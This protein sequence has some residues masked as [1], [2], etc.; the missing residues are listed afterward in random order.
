VASKTQAGDQIIVRFNGFAFPATPIYVR[1][2]NCSIFCPAMLTG[3]CPTG[4]Q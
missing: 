3:N 1:G 4:F 2:A